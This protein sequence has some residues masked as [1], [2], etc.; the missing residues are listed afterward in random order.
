MAKNNAGPETTENQANQ[1]GAEE[2]AKKEPTKKES[3]LKEVGPMEE[4][5]VVKIA[6]KDANGGS[7]KNY[8]W[9]KGTGNSR[10]LPKGKKFEV[11]KDHAERLVAK[12]AA[13]H[14]TAPAE[15][16]PKAPKKKEEE[17]DD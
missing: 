16:K 7:T 6:K 12:G 17:E 3:K 1:P 14:T 13:E 5:T 9:I 15:L 4:D 10:H 11:Q 2:K 8:T